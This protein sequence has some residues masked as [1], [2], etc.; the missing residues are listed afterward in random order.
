MLA[1]LVEFYNEFASELLGV[2][3]NAAAVPAQGGAS[4]LTGVVCVRR[5]AANG[6]R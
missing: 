3:L 2:A 4:K 1:R 5:H 6:D